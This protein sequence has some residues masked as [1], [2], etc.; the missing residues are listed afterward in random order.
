MGILDDAIR[1]HLELRRKHGAS[2]AE[3]SK[4]ETE[5]LS[6]ARREAPVAVAEESPGDE[7]AWDTEHSDGTAVGEVVVSEESAHAEPEAERTTHWE[8]EPVAREPEP[9]Y[10]PLLDEPPHA[11]S[12]PLSDEATYAEAEPLISSTDPEPDPLPDEPDA[13]VERI[14]PVEPPAEDV[15]LVDQVAPVQPP[16]HSEAAESE[17]PFDP[18]GPPFDGPES[19]EVGSETVALEPPLDEPPV[20]A[21]PP[22][23][24]SALGGAFSRREEV[25]SNTPLPPPSTQ[26]FERIEPEAA[27]LYDFDELSEPSTHL[28]PELELRDE[29]ELHDEP[30]PADEPLIEERP[31]YAPDA[32]SRVEA[33]PDDEPDDDMLEDTPDFLQETPEHDRLW[34]EQKPPRDFD[35]DD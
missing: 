20:D 29:P 30:E 32:A 13:F 3:I 22:R 35:F 15:V 19:I 4:K 33:P 24:R 9:V 34:F 16:E 18:P 12:H 11:Q 5:A 28:E 8:A 7:R 6:P 26:E 23:L 17:A 14:A 31:L 25:E 21:P 10:E 2:E 27:D 1:E